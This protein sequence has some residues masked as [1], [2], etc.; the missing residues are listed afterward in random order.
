MSHFFNSTSAPRTTVCLKSSS[1][2]RPDVVTHFHHVNVVDHH[3]EQLWSLYVQ[4]A[5]DGCEKP[6]PLLRPGE[7]VQVD[8]AQIALTSSVLNLSPTFIKLDGDSSLILFLLPSPE[9]NKRQLQDQQD[10]DDEY[11]FFQENDVGDENRDNEQNERNEQKSTTDDSENDSLLTRRTEML[12]RMRVRRKRKRNNE[13]IPSSRPGSKYCKECKSHPVNKRP[14]CK[15]HACA[16]YNC[17]YPATKGDRRCDKNKSHR[18]ADGTPA[19][20]ACPMPR[21]PAEDRWLKCKPCRLKDSQR[22]KN[23]MFK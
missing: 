7:V 22:K 23:A 18:T 8:G 12:S 15:Y 11:S 20:I 9:E 17:K 16:F 5:V 21:A 10:G 3:F 6:K 13:F 19:C 2:T 4:C 14:F 1:L